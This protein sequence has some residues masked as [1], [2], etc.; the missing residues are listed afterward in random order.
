MMGVTLLGDLYRRTIGKARLI[1]PLMVTL[2][3]TVLLYSQVILAQDA[4]SSQPATDPDTP[5]NAPDAVTGDDQ[6][7]QPE[8]QKPKTDGQQSQPDSQPSMDHSQMDHGSMP[9]MDHSQMDHGSMPGMDH[10]QMDHGSMPGMD[11]SSMDHGS[12]NH[13]SMQGGAAP[14]DARDPDAYSNGYTLD[15]GPYVLPGPRQLR[16]AD[17]H[18]FASLLVDRLEA[19]QTPDETWA[20]Y[21][22]HAWVGRDYDR[23]VFKAEGE[24]DNHAFDEMRSELLWG[25][26]VA[27]YW[28]TQLGIRYDSGEGP[29]RHWLAFGLEGLAPYWFEMDITAYVGEAGGSALNVNVE[30]ELLITQRLIL[31]PS[32]EA[33]FYGKDD[34]ERGIGSGLA[35]AKLG[36]RLRYEIYREVAPYVGV[37]W[38]GLFGDSAD[39]ARTAGMDS[40]QTQFIAGIRLLY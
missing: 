14:V 20:A 15:S 6:K 19:V 5:R 25:H 2:T 8:R 24:Y 1:A 31:Q 3:M 9:G 13:G 30:Y 28:N 17:E 12:M 23:A 16:M 29:K 27:A 35:E 18:N 21:D 40:T 38:A 37:E 22:V 4:T 26:A 33:D 7:P 32:L 36:L 39:Y 10:S 34:R 11:H